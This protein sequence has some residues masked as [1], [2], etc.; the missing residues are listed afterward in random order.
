[1][2][3]AC[4]ESCSALS[5]EAKPSWGETSTRT[6]STTLST[7]FVL[8]VEDAYYLVLR[9]VPHLFR[10]DALAVPGVAPL[11]EIVDGGKLD[12]GGEHEGVAHS[13]EPVHS[14]GVGHFGQRVSSADAQSCHGQDG[15][16]SC[17]WNKS[18]FFITLVSHLFSLMLTVYCSLTLEYKS[19]Q[20]PK[21]LSL[22]FQWWNPVEG[23]G[24]TDQEIYRKHQTTIRSVHLAAFHQ[25]WNNYPKSLFPFIC[26]RESSHF[27]VIITDQSDWA[28]HHVIINKTQ[29]TLRNGFFFF[30]L[31]MMVEMFKRQICV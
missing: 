30:F 5:S 8:Q 1:M 21:S 14:S 7:K 20:T 26:R 16:H 31:E 11:C 9:S 24:F 19:I 2:L 23:C 29:L 6:L 3:T 17:R 12:E 13:D 28:K 4:D 15:G 27:T 22:A 10:H 18:L 25:V